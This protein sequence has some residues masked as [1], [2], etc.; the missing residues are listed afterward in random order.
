VI[1]EERAVFAA[2]LEQLERVG[3]ADRA[4][5]LAV[6]LPYG[7]QRLLEIARAMASSPEMLM[8]DERPRALYEG[9]RTLAL[10]VQEIRDSVSEF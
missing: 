2:A 8:L 10:F 7:Q 9:D 4:S 1:R 3:L 5:E 6:N